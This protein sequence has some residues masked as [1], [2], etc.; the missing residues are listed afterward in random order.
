MSYFR[1]AILYRYIERTY[2]IC[3][4]FGKDMP[5]HIATCFTIFTLLK[6]CMFVEEREKFAGLP[7]QCYIYQKSIFAK[8][9]FSNEIIV[10][11][12]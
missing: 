6:S 7:L 12:I 11:T 3:C 2:V 8:H 1:E 9:N 5:E 4:D 10:N